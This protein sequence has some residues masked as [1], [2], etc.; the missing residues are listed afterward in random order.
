MLGREE[1]LPASLIVA[2]PEENIPQSGY[3]QHFQVNL[4]QA[5]QQ[6]RQAMGSSAKAEKTYFDRRVKALFILRGSKGLAL[7]AQTPG[8]A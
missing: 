7:L 8:T 6:V 3:V 4:R 5:H 1:L 2:P